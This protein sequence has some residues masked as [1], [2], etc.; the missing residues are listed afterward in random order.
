MAGRAAGHPG[1]AALLLRAGDRH[2][3]DAAGG[4]PPGPAPDGRAD[5]VRHRPARPR[6]AGAGPL[7]LEP[8]GRD[9]GGAASGIG[10]ERRARPPAGRQHRLTL[11]RS[12]RVADGEARH[13]AAPVLA[14]GRRR[15]T[16]PRGAG[17]GG[18]PTE[19]HGTTR[20]RSWRKPH[21]AT[22]ADTGRIVASALTGKDADDGPQ[23]GPLLEQV[24][25]AVASFTADGAS[26]RDDVHAAAAARHPDADV[27]VPPRSGAV[28]SGTGAT[29]PT[30]RDRHLRAIA[31][32]GRLGW[33][34]ASGYGW[35]A[36]VESDISRF[37]RVIGDGLR[38]RTDGRQATE[39]AIAAG[40]LNRM[41]D[42]GRPEYVR[43]ARARKRA[44]RT[45][46]VPSIHAPQ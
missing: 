42:L 37:E 35:R 20:R 7:D 15:S 22:D 44:G 41:L 19:K 3:P 21:L 33:Q 25:G 11:A 30:R 34:K 32:R 4:V 2:G 45:A 6:P 5:R 27:I 23:V 46:P 29:A 13:H 12:R 17:P 26:G 18:W 24:D 9:P 14:G 10:P 8:P 28:P 40:V 43:V 31:G 16:A 38:S 36:L 1:R 39:V